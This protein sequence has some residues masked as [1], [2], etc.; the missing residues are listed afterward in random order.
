MNVHGMYDD[1]YNTNEC[2]MCIISDTR[3]GR[4][5]QART[6]RGKKEEQKKI[7]AVDKCIMTK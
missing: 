7:P 1:M 2:E 4:Q 3:F 5:T 6:I